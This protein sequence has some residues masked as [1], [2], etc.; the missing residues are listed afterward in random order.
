MKKIGK[1]LIGFVCLFMILTSNIYAT[2]SSNSKTAKEKTPSVDTTKKVYDYAE[3]LTAS[4]ETSLY[5]KIQ[6]FIS[7]YNM[8]MVIVT[9]NT[10]NKSSA[11]AYA[12]DFYDYNNFG[13]GSN[14][15][16]ILFL[17]DMQN[18]E[19]WISTTGS[20]I[21]IYT[22]KRIDTILDYTY[23]KIAKKDYNGCAE[24]FIKYAKQYAAIGNDT[25]NINNERSVEVKE[26]NFRLI[27]IISIVATV[28][29]IVIG[30][31]THMKPKKQTDAKMYIST[32][33]KL[34]QKSDIFVNR[35]VTKTRIESSS[36][37]YSSGSSGH[38]SSTHSG[39][40]G[41]SHGGG[42]RRF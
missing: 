15:S 30:L 10:N 13:I 41:T 33:I 23:N 42:G 2:S 17:I 19:M 37:S 12:D 6:E 8:D 32:P 7:S 38:S 34:N 21:P 16:G 3:L 22:D 36:S 31:M 29:F 26:I 40:S 9:T 27:V 25:N 28:I 11:M 24:E 5:N 1:I 4:Q 14:K 39:S 18:R 35:H 20:A